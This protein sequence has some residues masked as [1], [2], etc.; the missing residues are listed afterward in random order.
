MA[1]RVGVVSGRAVKLLVLAAGLLGMNFTLHHPV[2]QRGYPLRRPR[3][4][5]VSRDAHVD[6]EPTFTSAGHYKTIW[7]GWS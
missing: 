4:E 5:D 7:E 1:L 6:L 3:G 2:A